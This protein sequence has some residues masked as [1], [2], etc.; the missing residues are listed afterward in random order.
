MLLKSEF[1]YWFLLPS[2]IEFFIVLMSVKIS[3]R[4]KSI[5]IWVLTTFIFILATLSEIIL[6]QI[7]FKNSWPSFIPHFM[8]GLSIVLFGIQSY[9][10]RK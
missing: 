8:I 10:K 2:I 3:Y 4:R 5:G 9:F 1:Y 6:Y 7:F